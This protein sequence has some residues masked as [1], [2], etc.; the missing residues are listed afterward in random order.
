MLNHLTSQSSQYAIAH[1][2]AP[3][4]II[5]ITPPYVRSKMLDCPDKLSNEDLVTYRD[6]ILKIGDEWRS[7]QDGERWRIAIVDLF[8]ALQKKAEETNDP[9]ALYT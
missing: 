6:A 1:Y 4:S 7:K 2:P 5:L 8:G 9:R 3:L